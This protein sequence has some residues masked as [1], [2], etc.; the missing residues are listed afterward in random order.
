MNQVCGLFVDAEAGPALEAAY[1]RFT[2]HEMDF[3]HEVYEAKKL[4]TRQAMA[5][6]LHVLGVQL[7]RLASSH[8]RSRDFTIEGLREALREVVAHFP[9]YRTY[10]TPRRAS[11]QDKRYVAWAV[12]QARKTAHETSIHDFLQAV[13]DTGLARGRAPP[14]Q[15]SAV[16]A[17]AMRVQQYSGPVMAK[18]F[19]DTALYRYNRLIALNEVGGDPRRF[20]F[21]PAAYH[22]A[23]KARLRS[24]PHSMLATATHDS[25]RGED[26]RLR[27]A[28][29]SE[30]PEEWRN[31]LVRWQRMNHSF[32][33]EVD[34]LDAPEANDEFF[35][36]QSM[37]GAWPTDSV[38][39]SQ[40]FVRRLMDATLKAIKEAKR[41][42]SW[43]EP[44]QAYE[45]ATLEF[46][47]RILDTRRRNPFLD[48]FLALQSRLER[49]GM[50]NGLAQT[51]LKL[52]SPGVPDLYQ[53][54]ELWQLALV[55]P[56]NRRPVDYERRQRLL[57]EVRD[58]P[59][60]ELLPRWRG[61]AVKLALIW[62]IL[63]LRR[64]RPELF[65]RGGYQPL[66]VRGERAQHVVAFAREHEDDM[67][68]VAVPRLVA[69][70]WDMAE[71]GPPLGARWRG[72]QV[73]LPGACRGRRLVDVLSGREVESVSRRVSAQLPAERI[74]ASFP[75]ALLVAADR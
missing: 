25:K 63:D 47:Q 30:M 18:G 40:D 15:R 38:Q 54:C 49:I 2:G 53:G 20:G 66:P 24:H 39:P 64:R 43:A 60:P 72:V 10:F 35:L 14:Y 11:D 45:Q 56:D 58:M 73:D 69:R 33:R 36:Y 17:L 21:S 44:N 65:E 70:L 8:W 61:G 50:V 57:A 46:V 6:E 19:E 68:I 42:T 41:R 71:D 5:S 67:A 62:R 13:L 27:I 52:T 74:F 9:I 48:D 34:G 4:I 1:C 37:L 16:F 23:C 51:L 3:E 28:A 22:Q 12:A 59:L 32:K 75:V 26:V 31:R 7:G 29:L 55:D